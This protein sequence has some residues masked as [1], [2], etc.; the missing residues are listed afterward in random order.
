MPAPTPAALALLQDYVKLEIHT[1]ETHLQAVMD[2][3]DKAGAGRLGPYTYTFAVS[4]I[5][6]YWRAL[7]EAT[8]FMGVQGQVT[9]AEEVKIETYC[10]VAKLRNAVEAV[11]RVHPYETPPINIVPLLDP[12]PFLPYL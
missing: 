5:T 4:Q 12:G 10:S 1:P 11:A 6:G 9:Q 3:L 2:A 8:P 7:G